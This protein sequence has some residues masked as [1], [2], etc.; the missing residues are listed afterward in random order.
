MLHVALLRGVNAGTQNRIDMKTLKATFEAIGFTDVRTYINSG[1]I[2]FRTTRKDKQRMAAKIEAAIKQE[3]GHD[4][5]T[6]VLDAR[7]IEEICA[8]LPDEWLNND[9]MRSEV[10]FLW[11]EIDKPD[12]VAKLNTKVVDNVIHTAGAILWMIDRKDYNKS[13]L[14]RLVGT[15]PYRKM[16]MRNV[17]TL[18]KLRQ[19][20]S[21]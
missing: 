2:V 21:A 12:L 4:V 6:L 14:A 1:N 15:E 19:M 13:G 10:M 9:S 17:N 16:T 18:R 5:K 3:F 11:Q 7:N 20:M 8:A